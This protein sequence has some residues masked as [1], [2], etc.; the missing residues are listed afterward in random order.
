MEKVMR[1]YIL[2]P[3]SKNQVTIPKP[4]REALGVGP[5]DRITVVVDGGQVRLEPTTELTVEQLAGILPPLDPPT[6]P[7]FRAEIR[8]AM[9]ERA[10]QIVDR[11]NDR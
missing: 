10:Q 1:K 5:G 11:M 7:D 2:R 4:V 8:E 3:S 9:E 6:S